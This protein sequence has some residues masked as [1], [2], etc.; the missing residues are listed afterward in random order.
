MLTRA[1]GAE[2][3]KLIPWRDVLA[4]ELEDSSFRRLWEESATYRAIALR[5]LDY[6]LRHDLTQEQLAARWGVSVGRIAHLEDDC[7]G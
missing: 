3:V 4:R 7:E 2:R 5:V 1:D 6:R